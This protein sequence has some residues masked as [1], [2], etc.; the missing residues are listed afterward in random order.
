MQL[1]K[2]R[3]GV[4]KTWSFSLANGCVKTYAAY[5]KKLSEFTATDYNEFEN[6]FNSG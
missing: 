6:S 4:V 2:D 5:I 1:L 3:C